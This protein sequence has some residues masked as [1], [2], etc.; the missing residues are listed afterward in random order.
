MAGK[1]DS[2]R[3]RLRFI[4]LNPPPEMR[5]GQKTVFGLQD[6]SQ[7]LVTGEARPDGGLQFEAEFEAKRV[8]GSDQPNLLGP[9][10]QGTPDKRFVYLSWGYAEAGRKEWIRRIKIPL[11]GLT[12]TLIETATTNNGVLEA[13]VDGRR[14][15]TVP[16][17]GEGWVIR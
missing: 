11:S 2:I 13:T 3:I 8:T 6:K 12:W 5:D 17:L 4:C 16:L 10:A 9:Y 15:A 1:Q 7:N 14:A